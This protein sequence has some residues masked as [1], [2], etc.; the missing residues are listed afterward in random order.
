MNKE[1]H[2]DIATA[3][4]KDFKKGLKT[5]EDFRR[6][7]GVDTTDYSE[8]TFCIGPEGDLRKESDTKLCPFANLKMCKTTRCI[9]FVDDKCSLFESPICRAHT[10][11]RE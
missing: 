3:I 9:A 5:L 11:N 7:G 6:V 8:H 10:T 4:D 1:R 2:S